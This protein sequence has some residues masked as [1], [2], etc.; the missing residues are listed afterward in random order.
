MLFPSNST[1]KGVTSGKL[2]NVVASFLRLQN[3]PSGLHFLC[4]PGQPRTSSPSHFHLFLSPHY[5]PSPAIFILPTPLHSVPLCLVWVYGIFFHILFV[6]IW[7]QS[8]E[9]CTLPRNGIY[10]QGLQET[11]SNNEKHYQACQQLELG[12]MMHYFYISTPVTRLDIKRYTH[13]SVYQPLLMTEFQ[14]PN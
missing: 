1:N 14:I 3:S 11:F 8:I 5:R 7:V 10:G 6:K 2:C 13:I 12:E 4:N 9:Q